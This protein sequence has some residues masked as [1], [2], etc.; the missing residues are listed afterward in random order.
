MA[1]GWLGVD[2]G[3]GVRV[4]LGKAE[5]WLRVGL[6]LAW[7]W[8]AVGLFVDLL[9]ALLWMSIQLSTLPGSLS[10]CLFWRV[11]LFGVAFRQGT[12][13]LGAPRF[14]ILCGARFLFLAT[15]NLTCQGEGMVFVGRH[16]TFLRFVV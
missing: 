11:L 3:L 5:A 10:I 7:R 12:T 6:G 8:L 1:E 16:F 2:S 9:A 13:F 14:S 4:G 15:T